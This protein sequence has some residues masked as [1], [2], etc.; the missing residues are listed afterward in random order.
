MEEELGGSKVE[1]SR[2][3]EENQRMKRE[4]EDIQKWK[5]DY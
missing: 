5:E 2:L 4:R 3:T 1:V